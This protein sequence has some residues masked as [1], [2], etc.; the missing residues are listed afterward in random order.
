LDETFDALTWSQ[1]GLHGKLVGALNVEGYWDGL[2][3]LIEHAVRERFVRSRYAGLL[4]FADT[5]AE[6]LDGFAAWRA[7]E[8]LRA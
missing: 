8:M 2:R 7:Q 5:P 6:L 3:A 1:L 4:L